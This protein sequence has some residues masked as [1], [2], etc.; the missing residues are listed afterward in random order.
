MR[1][2]EGIGDRGRGYEAGGG[3]MRQ[4]DRRHG[5]G[6]GGRGRIGGMGRG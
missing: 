5:E 4:G 1:Q 2:G 6:I 3:D